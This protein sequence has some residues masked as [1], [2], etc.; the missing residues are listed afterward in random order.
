MPFV[1]DL[2]TPSREMEAAAALGMAVSNRKAKGFPGRRQYEELEVLTRFCLPLY[3][4]TWNQ[5]QEGCTCVVIDPQGL[6][7]GEIKFDLPP[8]GPPLEP[9]ENLGEEEF[10]SFCQKAADA[11]HHSHPE[12]AEIT[13]LVPEP[14]EAELLLKE[15]QQYSM[16][17]KLEMAIEPVQVVEQLRQKLSE[18]DAGAED[19]LKLKQ[20][21][22]AY[23][24]QMVQ[25][26]N[27][28]AEEAKESS[29]RALEE[30]Q[31]QVGSAIAARNQELEKIR[32][33][34]RQDHQRQKDTL[35]SE[36]ERFRRQYQETGEDYWREKIKAE[37]EG[38]AENDQKLQETLK[39]LDEEEKQ[40]TQSQQE[41]IDNFQE[42]KEKRMQAFQ[43][44]LDRLDNAVS[45]L[46]EE[47]N[48]RIDLCRQQYQR[49]NE[50]T[51]SIPAHQAEKEYPVI[52]Y[53][54][55]YSG[56]RWQVFPPQVFNPKGLKGRFTKLIGLLHLPFRS[57]GRVGEVL[58]EKLEHMIPG[59]ELENRL[60]EE[61]LLQN[62]QFV[63]EAKG[64]LSELINQGSVD[65]KHAQL[66]EE[67]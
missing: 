21:V 38:L 41:K 1:T 48:Q 6:L 32:E 62:A 45:A 33:K 22:L 4:A 25:K 30:L 23:R 29:N 56:H 63:E 43:Q 3:A 31:Q 7:T 60:I 2:Y 8:D 42:E 59:H 58:A 55:R 51:V 65:K 61:D 12:T 26:I 67:F 34:A 39:E 14:E 19:W 50:L 36:L 11:A 37:E 27:K 20:K 66:F 46:S 57:A 40:F 15:D 52:F 17:A 16:E 5:K 44:R 49:V 64:G 10:I 47:I 24:D 18:Y 13:G 53:A 54:A 28:A 9:G 35:Q